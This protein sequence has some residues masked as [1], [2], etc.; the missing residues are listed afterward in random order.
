MQTLTT[1]NQSLGLAQ[2][3]ETL[4]NRYLSSMK[5]SDIKNLHDL[6]LEQ[7]EAPLFKAVIEHCRYN[8]SRAANMLGIS[9]GTFRT[10]LKK[11]FDDK[12]CGQR[13]DNSAQ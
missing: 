7:I 11:Y 8:Q 6:V 3:V 4:I 12:Y 2:S 13:E 9:R 5:L 1:T 10:K